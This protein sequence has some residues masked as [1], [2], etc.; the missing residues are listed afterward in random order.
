MRNL[1]NMFEKRTIKYDKLQDYGFIKKDNQYIYKSK[2]VNEQ[3]EV[4]ISISNENKYSKVIDSFDGS[5]Y[6]LVDVENAV[7]EFIGNVRD[8]YENVI[9]DILDKCTLKKKFKFDQTYEVISYIKEK[10]NDDFE[11][12]WEKYDDSAI[13]RNKDNNKW[14]AAILTVAENKLGIDSDR[15]VEVIDLR[16]QKEKIEDIIDNYRVFPGY[17]MNK[18]SWITIKLDNTVETEFIVELIDNSYRL[19]I[20]KNSKK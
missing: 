13:V 15:I 11:F 12:L 6:A 4:Q 14:Y 16:Y 3:F 2:I 9:Y 1:N 18:K 5:E 7:G 10:Y 8:E 20:E 17:H 19:N